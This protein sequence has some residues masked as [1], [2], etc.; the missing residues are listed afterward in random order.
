MLED[1]NPVPGKRKD[2]VP[3]GSVALDNEFGGGFPKGSAVVLSSTPSAEAQG[4]VQRFLKQLSPNDRP[5]LIIAKSLS[6]ALAF[7]TNSSDFFRVH[8]CG[9]VVSPSS[10]ISG[11]KNLD[12]LTELNIGI[13]EALNAAKPFRVATDI[14]SDLLLRHKAL[15]TRKWLSDFLAKLRTRDVTLLA[16]INPSMHPREEVEAIIDLFD[17]CIELYEGSVTDEPTKLVIRWMHGIEF[18]RKEVRLE[19]APRDETRKIVVD[20]SSVAVLDFANIAGTVDADWLSGG[21][22]ET[23]TVDLKKISSLKVT[24][25]ETVFQTLRRLGGGKG[26]EQIMKV[27]RSLGV[28][29]IVWGA[30]QKVGN[31]VRITAHFTDTSTGE[32]VDSTKLD[33]S[34]DDIFRLQDQ[35]I[36]T[37]IATLN[38]KISAVEAKKIET[39]QAATVEAYEYYA[40]GRQ[41]FSQFGGASFDQAQQYF[42][43]AIE[44]DEGYALAYSGLGSIHIFRFIE[45]TDPRDLD[46]GISH[47]Q[48]AVEHDPDLVEPYQWLAYAY[49]RKRRLSEAIEAGL[50]AIELDPTSFLAQYFLGTAYM[51]RAATGYDRESYSSAVNH[52]RISS[53]L[54]P[55]YGP[56]HMNLAW[57]YLLEGNYEGA[58]ANLNDTVKIEESGKYEGV[59]FV[60]G[61]TMMGNLCLRRGQLDE[62]SDW[63][64]RAFEVL[65][66]TEHVYQ[67]QFIALTYSGLGDVYWHKGS[68]DQAVGQYKTAV[69]VLARHPK[70]LGVGFYLI[71]AHLGMAKA[72]YRLGMNREAERELRDAL[73]LAATKQGYDFSWIWEGSDAEANYQIASCLALMNR[74]SEATDHLRRAIE[75][76]WRDASLI[77]T[78]EAFRHVRNE[79]QYNEILNQL[80]R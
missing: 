10:T 74:A 41:L 39:A 25:R 73:E 56:A 61:L 55:N 34:M 26:E 17:G 8:V 77:G 15:L 16:L 72:F 3:S 31:A 48:K 65:R 20:E 57:I 7:T 14:L 36:T 22:A 27:G 53:N 70:G 62:A 29:W 54:A 45:R 9:E 75:F 51:I 71:R 58:E 67:Q 37:L 35:I 69:E 18:A 28:R 46:A 12:N 19:E 30:F 42:E 43:K 5:S 32:I 1:Q 59:K 76:G 44:L 6:S 68:Y 24:S 80:G 66:R 78:D 79:A 13:S 52:F 50:R 64:R 63:Y 4:F 23:V 49:T 33:G 40:K 21:I 11:G 47:L 2:R 60:G 38:L